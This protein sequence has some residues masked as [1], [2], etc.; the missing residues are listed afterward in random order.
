MITKEKIQ[1]QL[2]ELPDQ[3]EL[4]SFLERIFLLE[5]IEK[6]REQIKLGQVYSHEDM[7]DR[8]KSWSI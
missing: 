5:K 3:F 6:A 1:E 8:I 7:K 4:D 2:D